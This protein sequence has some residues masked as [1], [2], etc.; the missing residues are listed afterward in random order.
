MREFDSP[1]S[2][3]EPGLHAVLLAIEASSKPVIAAI[4]SVA[5][6]GGLELALACHYRV[7]SSGARIA[8]S[9]VTMGLLPG[10]GGTGEITGTTSHWS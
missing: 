4:H 8:L 9:E 6:G 2:V 3:K 5:M 7:A 10:A 1:H